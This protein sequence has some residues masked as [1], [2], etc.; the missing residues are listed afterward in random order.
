MVFLPFSTSHKPFVDVQSLLAEYDIGEHNMVEMIL[1]HPQESV[2]RVHVF[3]GRPSDVELLN[4]KG[5]M[6]HNQLETPCGATFLWNYD[7][8]IAVGINSMTGVAVDLVPSMFPWTKLF[9]S[10]YDSPNIFHQPLATDW[11]PQ[12]MLVR[13]CRDCSREKRTCVPVVGMACNAC[14]PGRC[15]PGT[16]EQ[17]AR[18]KE[19][20]DVMVGMSFALSPAYQHLIQCVK[21]S[22]YYNG[23]PKMSSITRAAL[24]NLVKIRYCGGSVASEYLVKSSSE[25]HQV[26]RVVDGY[27]LVEGV[28]MEGIYGFDAHL[29]RKERKVKAASVVPHFGLPR[30]EWAVSLIDNALQN[31]G[32]VHWIEDCVMYRD[33]FRTCRILIVARITSENN[34]GFVVGWTF[35]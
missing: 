15:V 32:Y 34:M 9:Y 1:P 29:N 24:V 28:N 16:T 23:K 21:A 26:V 30:F 35:K 3:F 10:H 33:G 12:H 7:V 11:A 8:I 13:K 14:D 31:P 5:F 2:D 20:Y 25:S 18:I 4:F 27:M 22:S 17:L 6:K 19:C